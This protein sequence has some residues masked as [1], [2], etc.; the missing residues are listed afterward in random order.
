MIGQSYHFGFIGLGLIGGSIARILKIKYPGCVITAY[1]RS[2]APL[3]AAK[4]DGNI[5]N[6]VTSIDKDSFGECDYIFLCTPVQYISSYLEKL[7]GNIHDECTI[8]DVGSVKGFVHDAVSKYGL[9]ANFIG[10]HPMAGSEKTGYANSSANL[11]K[12]AYYVIT[13][14]ALTTKE[15][16]DAY[17]NLVKAMGSKPVITDCKTHD[18][19]VAGISHLPHLI[20]GSLVNLVK[21][22]DN[23]EQLMKTVAAGGF[24]DITRIASSSPEMWEQ[25]CQT[26]SDSIVSLLDDYISSLNKIRDNVANH[27]EGYVYELF[28]KSRNYRNSIVDNN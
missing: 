19:T 14:T 13:P 10:G 12:G 17:E 20:A 2:R 6:I 3:E 21:D 16:L 4:A 22:S 5:D 7:V 28:E 26:N 15:R 18:Y 24:K 23:E 27:T 11:L 9:D 1:S 25:I 8:T